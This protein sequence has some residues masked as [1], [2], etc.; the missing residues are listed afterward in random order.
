VGGPYVTL[1][2]AS[3][4]SAAIGITTSSDAT[5]IFLPHYRHPIGATNTAL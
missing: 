1:G 3:I 2:T 4:G 5:D